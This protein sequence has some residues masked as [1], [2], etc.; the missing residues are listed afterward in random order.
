[1]IHQITVHYGDERVPEKVWSLKAFPLPDQ[2]VG[3]AFEDIAEKKKAEER[4]NRQMRRLT[5]LRNID[6]AIT[7]SL[8][9]IPTLGELVNTTRRLRTKIQAEHFTTEPG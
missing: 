7:S 4:I 8:A 9:W 5:A 3:V 6:R 1:M 2:A